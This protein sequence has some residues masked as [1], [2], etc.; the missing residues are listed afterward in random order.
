M[1]KSLFILFIIFTSTS[2]HFCSNVSAAKMKASDLIVIS[3]GK[4]NKI[5][6]NL[7][8]GLFDVYNSEKQLYIKDVFA[9]AKN[10][11][12]LYS[13]KTYPK[14]TYRKE[15]IKDQLGI[16]I[17]YIIRSFGSDLP[18]MEQNFY[19]YKQHEYFVAELVMKGSD[20]TSNYM[21]P[22]I[23]NHVKLHSKGDQRTLFV[24]F[25][26]DTFIRYNAKPMNVGIENTSSEV[27]ALYD[28]SSR[29]GIITGSLAHTV[30]K[31]GVKMTGTGDDLSEL[32]VW[33]GYTDEKVTR[34]NI[35]H[36]FLSG[37]EISSPKMFIGY[38]QDWR[39]G[40]EIFGA[41]NRKVET[42]YV[43]D[44][45]QATP[46]GWN[47]WGVL[48]EKLNYEK[49]IQV[50]DFFAEELPEFRNAGTAYIDL[51]SY[52][53][54][55]TGGM[56]G[57][58][59]KLTAFADYCKSKGL[60]PGAY[61]APFT[62]WGY[63]SGG[64]ALAEGSTYQFKELWTKVNGGFHDFDGAR[65]LDPTHPGTRARVNFIIDKLKSCG[66]KMI[67]IDFLGHAAVEADSFFDKNVTTGMQAYR[68]GMEHLT[69]RLNGQ[70][71]VYAAISPSLA[72][73]RYAHV[74]RI[75]CDAWKTIKDTEYTVNSVNYG[76]WQTFL[77]NYIDADHI[78]FGT[79]T[80]G[81]NRARL[82]S[83][84]ISGTLIAG[85]DFSIKGSWTDASK[86]LLQDKELLEIGKNGIAF[87][88]VEGNTGQAANELFIREINGYLY[89]AVMNFSEKAKNFN[90]ALNRIG[91]KNRSYEALEL[92]DHEKIKFTEKLNLNVNGSDAK[93]FKIKID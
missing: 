80:A 42:P 11:G 74:R 88:P 24:P 77:Y 87:M 38:F 18:E 33:G 27:G 73:G 65:A 92:F 14:R 3:Y 62:D 23:T 91:L 41:T 93:I 17:K 54:N 79:E 57:D 59:S 9:V 32:V 1:R 15:R 81:A 56:S 84:L 78:V 63:K 40:M 82:T 64:K 8:T 30:W 60:E 61:W 83:A 85:D 21:A 69:D 49:A 28:N 34:D 90:I 70:M 53:D 68:I 66:F 71:L 75:A 7:K 22:L 44:W 13:S 48:Q 6:Y 16:G 72:T 5:S 67:K 76:W 36:G 52:W 58:Y 20:L 47:S 26:N 43:F 35:Q 50:V 86:Q 37:T 12:S 51:D 2:L 31:T 19:V 46:F 89:L 25:D 10:K 45:K 55:L 29:S 39:I 4:G